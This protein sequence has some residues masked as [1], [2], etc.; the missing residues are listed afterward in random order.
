MDDTTMSNH[1][2]ES[3]FARFVVFSLVPPLAVIVP[4]SLL[5]PP[6]FF[7]ALLFEPLTFYATNMGLRPHQPTTFA[8]E[9]Q[10]WYWVVAYSL[11]VG[12]ISALISRRQSFALGLLTMFVVAALVAIATHTLMYF[13]APDYGVVMP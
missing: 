9:R 4:V 13:C 6:I 1:I 3:L 2:K 10:G 7:T 5:R 11:L 8:F 12:A